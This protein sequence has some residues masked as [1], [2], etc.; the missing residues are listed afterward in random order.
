[1][2]GR[3]TNAELPDAEVRRLQE[4]RLNEDTRALRARVLALRDRDWPLRAIGDAVGVSR[5]SVQVWETRSRNDDV[6]VQ[7]SEALD[8]VP[9]LPMDARG[10]GVTFK[11]MKPDVPVDKRDELAEAAQLAKTVRRWTADNAPERRASDKLDEML[12]EYVE[13]RKVTPMQVARHA[14]VTRRAVVA[15]LERIHERE[16][17][18]A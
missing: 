2:T 6:I 7:L 18:S 13:R 12:I 14:G 11:K 9:A 16:K 8:D 17:T 1:M 15:R 4:L 10:S 3:K 5:M